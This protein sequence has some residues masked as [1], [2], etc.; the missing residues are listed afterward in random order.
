MLALLSDMVASRILQISAGWRT[1]KRDSCL[2]GF[3]GASVD[4]PN[5][6]YT[7]DSMVA[8]GGLEPSRPVRGCG[9]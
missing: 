4:S 3:L 7:I 9:F 1:H 6:L 8:G 5:L 2:G